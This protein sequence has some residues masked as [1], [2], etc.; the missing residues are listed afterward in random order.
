MI[1]GVSIVRNEADILELTIRH[2]LREGLELLLIADNDSD[3][4][5][6]DVLRSCAARDPRVHWT[7]DGAGTFHQAQTVTGLAREAFSRGA[8]WIVPFDADEFWHAPGGLERALAGREEAGL[9]VSVVNYV[10]RREQRRLSVDALLQVDRRIAQPVGPPRNPD[11][12]DEASIS[13]LELAYPPKWISRAGAR[14]S[15]G[16]GNHTIDGLDGPTASIEQIRCL[17]V[18]LR[19][20][21]VLDWKARH[22]ERLAEAGY[23]LQHGWHVRRIA[24]LAAEGRLDEEWELN[25][26]L[27]GVLTAPDGRNVPL[28]RDPTLRE[29]VAS[30]LLDRDRLPRSNGTRASVTL[31]GGMNARQPGGPI[32]EFPLTGGAS[33]RLR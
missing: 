26:H 6:R 18:P 31:A 17:H 7:R 15:I 16:P 13:Y 20:R 2:H 25:S 23:P 28:E 19:A 14:L 9:E 8:R 5:T 21:A 10:Q 12:I 11:L 4:G 24:H 27:A 3:D 22:G 29:L 33:A 30:L 1:A 32:H